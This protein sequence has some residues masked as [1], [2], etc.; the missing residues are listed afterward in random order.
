VSETDLAERFASWAGSIELGRA[1]VARY[2]EPHRRYHTVEHLGEVLAAVDRSSPDD[3]FAVELAAWYHD[4]IYDPT[5]PAGASEARSAELAGVE[6]AR[7]G[8][9]PT[10]VAEV[11][12]LVLLTAGHLVGDDDRNGVALADADLGIL[13]ADPRRYWRYVADVRSEYR[14]VPDEAWGAGRSAVLRTFL[15]RDRIYRTDDDA[16]RALE[17]AARTNLADEL[18]SLQP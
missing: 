6:L 12:R 14:H 17:A 2:A 10:V 16:H 4:A 18:L 1:L 9:V 13:G 3:P 7:I 11:Q 8:V 5:D 15:D